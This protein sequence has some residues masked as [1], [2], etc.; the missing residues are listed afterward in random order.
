HAAVSGGKAVPI[1]QPA[2]RNEAMVFSPDGALLAWSRLSP[3]DPNWDI[4]VMDLSRPGEPR[5]A[6]EGD[7]AMQPLSISPDKR[8]VLIEKYVSSIESERWLLDL[9]S[10]KAQRLFPSEQAVSFG[11]G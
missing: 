10:G 4:M 6:L 1:S 9:Y 8:R 11:G 5:V 7:G 3:G 2:T